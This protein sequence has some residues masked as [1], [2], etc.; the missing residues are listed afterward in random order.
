MKYRIEEYKD[1]FEIA[2][3]AESTKPIQLERKTKWWQSKSINILRILNPRTTPV[4]WKKVW[5]VDTYEMY[6]LKF[7]TIEECNAKIAELIIEDE[8]PKINYPIIHEY[9]IN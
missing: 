5:F 2:K 3:K 7:D 9:D 8:K 4:V 6:M 1:H